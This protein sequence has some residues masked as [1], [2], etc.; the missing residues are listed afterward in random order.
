MISFISEESVGML[1]LSLFI[2]SLNFLFLLCTGEVMAERIPLDT[3]LNWHGDEMIW[4][5][6]SYPFYAVNK[7][8]GIGFLYY[9]L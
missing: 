1:P 6:S 2:C 8:L 7:C 4:I 3:E 5:K 9:H